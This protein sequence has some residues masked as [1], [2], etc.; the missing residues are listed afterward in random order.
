MA[1]R[2]EQASFVPSKKEG[3]TSLFRIEMS[4]LEIKALGN[5]LRVG[6]TPV[7]VVNCGVFSRYCARAMVLICGVLRDVGISKMKLRVVKK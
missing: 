5:T 4:P 6:P 3:S 7:S 2:S 1:I